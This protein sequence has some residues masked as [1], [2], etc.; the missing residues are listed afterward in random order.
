[1]ISVAVLWH[2]KKYHLRNFNMFNGKAY[3]WHCPIEVQI[4]WYLINSDE[5]FEN[6]GWLMI[7]NK[8]KKLLTISNL[9]MLNLLYTFSWNNSES[10]HYQFSFLK[11]STTNMSS[12]AE[13][14]SMTTVIQHSP[15]INAGSCW[16][17]EKWKRANST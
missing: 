12:S 8:N 1:M 17:T 2:K 3:G 13:N 10:N 11:S 14:S 6:E 9:N 16:M 4:I 5:E 15:V 7:P